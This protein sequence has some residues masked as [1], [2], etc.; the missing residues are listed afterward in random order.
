MAAG[1][2]KVVP[3]GSSRVRSIN[4]LMQDA[5]AALTEALASV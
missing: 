1:A 3:F 5:V 2:M 4:P